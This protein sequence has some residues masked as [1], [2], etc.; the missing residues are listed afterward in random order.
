MHSLDL[1]QLRSE[2]TLAA[3]NLADTLGPDKHAEARETVETILHGLEQHG[4][5]AF[6]KDVM[7]G[8]L[9]A[10]LPKR[11]DDPLPS[12]KDAGLPLAASA[13]PTV[14]TGATDTANVVPIKP[15]FAQ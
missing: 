6:L 2:L 11:D 13:A 1:N 3:D 8:K 10:W 9:D 12:Y 14:P 7:A 15:P 5:E 4:A